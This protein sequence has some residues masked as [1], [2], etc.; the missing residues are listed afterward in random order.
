MAYR[1]AVTSA[2]RNRHVMLYDLNYHWLQRPHGPWRPLN[3]LGGHVTSDF[4]ST[5]L[6]TLVLMCILPLM[7][8]EAMAAS[9]WPQRLYDL[10]FEINN[11]DYPGIDVHIAS[12][13]LRGHGSLQ[14]TSEVIWPQIWHQQPWLHWYPCAYCLQWPPR[15]W[16]P[17]N[18]LRGHMTLDLTSATLVTLV[19]MC[20]LP[21]MASE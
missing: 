11:L 8:S 21:Q 17:P 18:D 14:M 10:K 20:I 15:P 5:T 7:A 9:K 19:S 1:S 3:G 16:R 2:M 6:I 13:D 4:K 12:N